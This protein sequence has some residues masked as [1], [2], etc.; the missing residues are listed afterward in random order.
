MRQGWSAHKERIPLDW[1]MQASTAQLKMHGRTANVRARRMDSA[2]QCRIQYAVLRRFWLRFGIISLP[3]ILKNIQ[4]M[5]ISKFPKYIPF[6][7]SE[8]MNETHESSRSR[9]A[10]MPA[11]NVRLSFRKSFV[12]SSK[13]TMFLVECSLSLTYS[14]TFQSLFALLN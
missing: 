1:V 9:L 2:P 10:T 13:E 7:I 8:M 4:Y 6:Q 14:P 11:P 5:L 3:I 12:L